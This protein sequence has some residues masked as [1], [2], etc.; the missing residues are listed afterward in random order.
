MGENNRKWNNWQRIH[1]QN[2]SSSYKSMPEKQPNQ[3]V[4]KRPKQTFLQGRHI[5][6]VNKRMKRCSTSLIISEM[7]IKTTMRYHLTP[8]RMAVIKKT[9][10]NQCWWGCGKKGWWECK[11]MQPLYKT[12]WRFVKKLKIGL[13]YDP[14]ILLLGI[15]LKKIKALIRKHICL[16]K[17]MLIAALFTVDKMQK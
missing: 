4:G 13:L 14:A 7:Q 10:T 15:Y 12:D 2:T 8:V 5:H 9:R 3:K 11:L 17:T 16:K 1:F 6:M